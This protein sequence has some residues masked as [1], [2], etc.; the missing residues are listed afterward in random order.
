MAN[1]ARVDIAHSCPAS[2]RI[3][4]GP[5]RQDFDVMDSAILSALSA[6]G[7]ATLGAFASIG[8]SWLNQH[9]QD[10]SQRRA[11]DTARRERLFSDF[12]K[13]AAKLYIDA[14]THELTDV[15]VLVPLYALKAEIYVCAHRRDTADLA[16]QVLL[17]IIRTY[18]EPNRDFLK[19]PD[20][21]SAQ[22]DMLREFTIACREELVYRR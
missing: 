1:L 5:K 14:L 8:A 3:Q 7:G 13:L 2:G 22:Y 21:T 12:I 4:A 16:D 10:R 9:Y 20:L 11:Q 18:Y 17:A 6:L 19:R 15:S